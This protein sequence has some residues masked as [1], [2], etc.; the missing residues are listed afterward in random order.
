MGQAY[1]TLLQPY[2]SEIR[3]ARFIPG[4]EEDGYSAELV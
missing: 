1:T 2:A 3:Y 4:T